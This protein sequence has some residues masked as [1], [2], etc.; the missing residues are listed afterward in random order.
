MTDG[1]RGDRGV[2]YLE[3]DGS[4]RRLDPVS[5]LTIGRAP[6]S[7]LVLDDQGVS[8]AH[9]VLEPRDGA[10]V[11]RDVGSRNGTSLDGQPVSARGSV[12]HNGATALIGAHRLVLRREALQT[13]APPPR[14]GPHDGGL[15]LNRLVRIGRAPDN[16]LVL[17]EP[18]ISRRHAEVRP[19]SPPTIHD[20]G[21]R[22]GLRHGDRLVRVAALRPGTEVGL[23]PYRLVADG[24]VLRVLDDRSAMALRATKVTVAV[25]HKT[26]LQP[27][28]MEVRPGQLVALI[29]ESGSGKTT[30][31]K[32]LAGIRPPTAGDVLL[33]GDPIGLRQTE[34]GYVPQADTVH[35]LLTVREAL[36]YAARLRL[37]SD[38]AAAELQDVVVRALDDLGLAEHA[39]TR[40]GALSGGQRKRAAVA[41]ELIGSPT[42]LFLDEPTSGLDP[43]LERRIMRLLRELADAGRGVVVVTHAT[44]S[45][46]LC[47]AVA[48]MGRGGRLRF[49]GA[50]VDALRHFDV[51]HFDE[52]Y[53]AVN[54]NATEPDSAA[55]PPAGRRRPERGGG[56]VLAG[57]SFARHLTVL[58]GRYAR[59]VVRDRKTLAVLLGQV[60]VMAVLIAVLFPTGLLTR[61][62][63]EPGRTAQFLFL[64]ITAAV[65][66]GLIAS[67]RE[68]VKEKAILGR[69]LAVGARLD[70]YLA[71]KVIVLFA[72]AV[73]QV[74]VL[75]AIAWLLQPLDAT[76]STYLALAGILV[77]AAWVAITLGLVVSTLAGSVDQATSFVPLLL[78][79]QLLFAG[80]L[81]SVQSMQTPVQVLAA[82]TFSRWA[83]D[84]AGAALDMQA[85]L[86]EDPAFAAANTY[87]PD[88]FTLS[89][90]ATMAVLVG[91][92]ALQ[93]LLT[94]VL[95]AR[96]AGH[97]Q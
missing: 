72:L 82:L 56:H 84:G 71:S 7:G 51:R 85:R 1:T 87:G 78:I 58:T 31:M 34:V 13:P 30:L 52:L 10:Y 80:A 32:A 62:D 40:I 79:P 89:T 23:G 33:N 16:D 92:L 50:P 55:P 95:T 54:A 86:G 21:S 48:V 39:E 26:I 11:L 24:D 91:F 93:L 19:G 59:I 36:T 46:E 83:F 37:P 75:C 90:P 65:W 12:L 69:E 42:M 5:P 6:S 67:C 15:P 81:I 14:R 57:R 60:P 44:A 73:V 35:G 63:A 74:V 76:A 25:G 53:E 88:F 96:R 29:G 28:S 94:G 64:L 45:L 4:L 8:W 61:P 22:N 38:T 2:A 18:N 3:V 97:E 68:I 77:A 27:T 70:A 20:V 66:V 9:A 47:D 43:G 49:F 41:T 17:D